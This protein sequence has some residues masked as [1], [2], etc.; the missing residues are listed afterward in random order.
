MKERA[1]ATGHRG[2]DERFGGWQQLLPRE[3]SSEGWT[4]IRQP[5]LLCDGSLRSA[6]F[7]GDRGRIENGD[8]APLLR[9]KFDG[10]L[11]SKSLNQQ[12]LQVPRGLRAM[13][14]WLNEDIFRSRNPCFKNVIG[15]R[16]L[17]G[18][19]DILS[20]RTS[21]GSH[22]PAEVSAIK[23][24]P[25]PPMPIAEVSAGALVRRISQF[26]HVSFLMSPGRWIACPR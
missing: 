3:I 4:V 5:E 7:Q 9:V 16:V 26:G 24:Q 20:K 23:C 6:F 15:R 10:Q 1:Y 21:A 2:D 13:R 17:A 22:G 18:A 14:S 11:Q 8:R 19:S 12:R 25:L